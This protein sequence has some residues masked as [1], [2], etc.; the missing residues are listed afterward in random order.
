MPEITVRARI[1]EEHLRAYEAE[2]KRRGVPVEKLDLLQGDSD[3]LIA[4]AGTGGSRSVICAG[5]ALVEVAE[6]VIEKGMAPWDAIFTPEQRAELVAF[7]QS[8]QG[9]DPPNAKAP[10]GD[11]VE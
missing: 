6:A 5:S 10:E 11:L 9:T 8:I 4:G 7:I 2:A 3:A 1:S